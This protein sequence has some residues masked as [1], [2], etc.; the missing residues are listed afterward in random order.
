MGDHHLLRATVCTHV[1]YGDK[2]DTGH[3]IGDENIRMLRSWV[4]QDKLWATG[5][6]CRNVILIYIPGIRRTLTLV[7]ARLSLRR[8][9]KFDDIPISPAS[10]SPGPTCLANKCWCATCRRWGRTAC[11][12]RSAGVGGMSRSAS[13]GRRHRPHGQQ[14]DGDTSVYTEK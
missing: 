5:Q 3:Y 12:R 8:P 14:K 6:S 9:G 11:R 7:G 13:K 4:L 2:C 10:P 1:Y